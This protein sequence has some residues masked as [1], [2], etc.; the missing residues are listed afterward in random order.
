MI[1]TP[2]AVNY[3]ALH[4]ESPFIAGS[5]HEEEWKRLEV[6]FPEARFC[7]DVNQYYFRLS[8]MNEA[9]KKLL[10][11]KKPLDHNFEKKDLSPERV[12]WSTLGV[13]LDLAE[14]YPDRLDWRDERLYP[15]DRAAL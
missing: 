6:Q 14:F 11:F 8:S 9:K 2:S 15:E 1:N 4:S 3:G 12:L 13:S 5:P 7:F 10:E